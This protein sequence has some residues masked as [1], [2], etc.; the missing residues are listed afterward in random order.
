VGTAEER[1]G[2]RGIAPEQGLADAGGT[3]DIAVHKQGGE[4]FHAKTVRNAQL[5]QKV[6]VAPPVLAESVIIPHDETSGV[7]AF[8]K[9]IAHKIFGSK[10]GCVSRKRQNKREINSEVSETFQ[11]MLQGNQLGRSV[12]AAQHAQGVW[13]KGDDDRRKAFS[14]GP[15]DG[16]EK[17]FLMPQVYAVKIAYGHGAPP[18]QSAGGQGK[19]TGVC[20]DMHVCFN[21]QPA[22]ERRSRQKKTNRTRMHPCR[23]FPGFQES[24][25]GDAPESG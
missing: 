19:D 2:I 6:G 18:G 8:H 16:A 9:H 3:D 23:P 13:G 7:E 4:F 10:P 21:P 25:V 24:A 17:K 1:G 15:G 5:G 11:F 22:P 20:G 12:V 14:A